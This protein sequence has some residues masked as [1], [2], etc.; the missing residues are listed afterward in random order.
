MPRATALCYLAVLGGA[1]AACAP[2]VPGELSFQA[3]VMPILAAS[4]VRCHGGPA[5]GGAPDRFRIDTYGDLAALDPR[6]PAAEVQLGG[7]AT[8]AAAIAARVASADAPMPPRVPLDDWQI[9]LLAKWAADGAPRGAARPGNRPPAIELEIAPA[10]GGA[11]AI[12]ARVTDPDGDVVAGALRARTGTGDRLVGA[13][14]SGEL[15]LAWTPAGVPP[16]TYPLVALLDDGATVH[17]VPAGSI[18]VAP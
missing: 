3:D 18:T 12:R 9:E 2:D 6:D 10:A 7:A 16:G 14:R 11:L 5:L 15:A 4:C 8:Y 17:E 13:V 1:P